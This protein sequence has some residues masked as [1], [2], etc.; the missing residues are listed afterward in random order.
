MHWFDDRR[1][2]LLG[3]EKQERT[4]R[5]SDHDALSVTRYS[6][7]IGNKILV[8]LLSAL[9]YSCSEETGIRTRSGS[10]STVR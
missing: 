6:T 10:Y 7:V 5:L 4:G 1:M 9:R 2:K 3:L 8:T